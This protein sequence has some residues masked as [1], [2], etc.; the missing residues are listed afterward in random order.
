MNAQEYFYRHEEILANIWRRSELPL[1]NVVHDDEF[2]EFVANLIQKNKQLKSWFEILRDALLSIGFTHGDRELHSLQNVMIHLATSTRGSGI[3]NDDHLTALLTS[4]A[5]QSDESYR[6]VSKTYVLQEEIIFHLQRL[7]RMAQSY[8]ESDNVKKPV[9]QSALKNA[10]QKA[11]TFMI[12]T[13]E[14]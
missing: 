3:F 6:D 11:K 1:K 13:G 10:L 7:S 5:I 14:I 12:E 9:I 8:V 4:E 2:P